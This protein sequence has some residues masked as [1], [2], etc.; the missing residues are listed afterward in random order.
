MHTKRLKI[1]LLL[2]FCWTVAVFSQ[3]NEGKL[4][5]EIS[6]LS[7]EEIII[8]IEKTTDYKFYYVKD[9]LAVEKYSYSFQ[10]KNITTILN[11]VLEGT[12]LNFFLF[13]GN[14]IILSQNN[15][16]YSTLPN[17]FFEALE[18]NSEEK[19]ITFQN[20]RNNA[21]NIG[22]KEIETIK[23]GKQNYS[24]RNKIFTI[25]GVIL[26]STTL[27]P[28]PNLTITED[29][30]SVI[31]ITDIDGFYNLKLPIGE[32]IL[33]F[34][35]MGVQ[36][37][38][39]RILVYNDGTL[40]LS[41]NEGFEQLNEV[42]VEAN[43]HV[44]I[45]ETISGTVGIDIE[46]SKNIPIILGERDVLK[47]ATTIPGIS[48]TGEGS[49]GFNVRGGKTDQNL[50]LFDDAVIYNPQHFFGIFSALN[51]FAIG[52]IKIYKGNI[53]SEFGGRLSSVFDIKT[54][55]GNSNKFS[56]E[57]SIGP[58]TSNVLLEIPVLKEKSSLLI[59][60]RGAYSNWILKSLDDISLK[61]SSASFYD[62]VASY[63]HKINDNNNIKVTG[64]TSKD[65]YSITTDS[66]YTYKNRLG[67]LKWDHK[68][69]KK[70]SGKLI[71]NTSNYTFNIGFEGDANNDFILNYDLNET[72]VKLK[73]NYLFKPKFKLD[74]GISSK[75]YRIN[76]GS[77]KP[78]N[79][80]NIE[81][82]EIAQDKGV[83]SS[84]FISRNFDL[85]DDLSIDAGL[86]YS[87][88]ASLGKSI[89]REYENN[90]P[91]NE[92][93]VVKE[94]NYGNNEVIK[95][96]GFP[97]FRIS[98]RYKFSEEMS[99]K[100]GYS[101]SVQYIHRLSNNTTVSP[102]DTWKLSDLNIKPQ[103]GQQLSLG[104]FKNFN[105]NNYEASIEGFYKKSKNILDFKT[106][107][108]LLMNENI[109]T[110]V[111]QGDGKSYGVEILISKNIGRLNGWLGYT[112][113]RSFNRL[114]SSFEEEKINNGD[115]F[116]SNFDKPHDISFVANYKFTKR[117][118]FSSNFVYQTG[119]PIT[120][121]VG[122]FVYDDNEYV[123]FSDRNSYRIPDFIRLDIGLNIEGN[124]RIKKFAHSFWTISV[125]NV[126]GRSNP[127]SVYFTNQDDKIKAVQTSI[128]SIPV[129]SITYN[130]KF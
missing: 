82:L 62:F 50:I 88:F 109:E 76:P 1:I 72:E 116:P 79:N 4:S 112:Y 53:P 104:L 43:A 32:H 63:N 108:Q 8:E 125:Y 113:S 129:P 5:L 12:N 126:L 26:N 106:G 85:S 89:Q 56:G 22:K 70:S 92:E 105:S 123:V 57:G 98:S 84:L 100:A 96:Y 36:N 111:L 102:V 83:E 9:W 23:I 27:E 65:D 55:N 68:F 52:S 90:Q 10:S 20:L 81:L 75:L 74:F 45:E 117:F 59:G 3:K 64:Y 14:K 30:S 60:G 86:R 91:R 40:N 35:S 21:K 73:A 44:N 119:R 25:S 97:E 58:V 101:S 99:L 39:K 13:E 17:N 6:K 130:F 69:S 61:N 2:S 80:S 128:F 29:K 124:H 33:E 77:I 7:L 115:F 103:T 41:L 127:F 28:I 71:I 34:R 118:S 42:V 24:S 46:D 19:Q 78:I 107:A 47:V 11:S 94:I 87:M 114:D 110:E 120:I 37:I 93:T 48:T 122:N 18:N 121:P 51:P 95:T 15:L 31:V 66:I 16:I 49:T 54:K 38:K 67:S